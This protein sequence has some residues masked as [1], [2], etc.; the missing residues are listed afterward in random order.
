VKKLRK[1]P[2]KEGPAGFWTVRRMGYTEA[3]NPMHE[4]VIIG[5]D[6]NPISLLGIIR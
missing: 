2:K 3:E 4:M 1:I 6:G 5:G